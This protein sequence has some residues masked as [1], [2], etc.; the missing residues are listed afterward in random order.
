MGSARLGCL[1]LFMACEQRTLATKISTWQRFF[2][3]FSIACGLNSR[4]VT[5]T[6]IKGV[7]FEFL[8]LC[9]FRKTFSS[10]QRNK[11]KASGSFVSWIYWRHSSFVKNLKL[12]ARLF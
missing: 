7:G 8:F 6:A 3:R 12:F 5:E 4:I 11:I 10:Q 2:R 1:H 9:L